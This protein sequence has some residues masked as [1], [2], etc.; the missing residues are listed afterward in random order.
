MESG[1]RLLEKRSDACVETV[2]TGFRA[3]SFGSQISSFC[4]SIVSATV[5]LLFQLDSIC[6]GEG[7]EVCSFLG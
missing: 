5:V 6:E 2:F 1:T 4:F 7:A 3:V